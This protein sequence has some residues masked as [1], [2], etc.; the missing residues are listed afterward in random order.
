MLR[1]NFLDKKGPSTALTEL[2]L[3]DIKVRDQ[4]LVTSILHDIV[5][6]TRLQKLTISKIGGLESRSVDLLCKLIAEKKPNLHTI[7]ISWNKIGT[8]SMTR[9][10]QAARHNFNIKSLNI[11]F[12]PF[13]RADPLLELGNFIR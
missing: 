10:M 4:G 1:L 2:R 6:E 13:D 9:L 3:V 7:D 11:A 5:I 12:N 8:K